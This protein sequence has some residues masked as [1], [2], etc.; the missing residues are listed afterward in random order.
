MRHFIFDVWT[1]CP[2]KHSI[3]LKS[4][5]MEQDHFPTEREV[6]ESLYKDEDVLV[7]FRKG[8]H[9]TYTNLREYAE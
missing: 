8:K 7:Y 4:I 3:S 6:M 1:W 9:I 2:E 5:K